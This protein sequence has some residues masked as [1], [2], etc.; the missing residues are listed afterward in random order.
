MRMVIFLIAAT[1]AIFSVEPARSQTYNPRY[2][3]CLQ[4]F[5]PFG[6][7]SCSYPSMAACRMSVSPAQ[8]AQCV[9]NP[10]FVAAGNA[11]LPS[12]MRHRPVRRFRTVR[13]HPGARR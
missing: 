6:G 11:A 1:A 2:P 5:G 4:T 10:Y 7:I 3:V 12:Q 8:S 9:V 13:R